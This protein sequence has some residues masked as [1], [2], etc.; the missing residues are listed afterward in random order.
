[1]T[2]DQQ[3]EAIS[4]QI[5]LCTSRLNELISQAATANLRVDIDKVLITEVQ[6][7]WPCYLLHITVLKEV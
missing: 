4:T 7:K 6:H 3:I 2:E 5:M 1:M